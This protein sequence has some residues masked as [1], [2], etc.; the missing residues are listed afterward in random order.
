MASNNCDAIWCDLCSGF[1]QVSEPLTEAQLAESALIHGYT[2]LKRPHGL[3]NR[4]VC[5]HCVA[6]LILA[7]DPS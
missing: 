2:T 6:A 7:Q 4:H 3:A 5:V 1:F